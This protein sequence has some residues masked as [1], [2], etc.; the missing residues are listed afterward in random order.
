M[1]AARAHTPSRQLTDS[2]GLPSG[3]L[4]NIRLDVA[5]QLSAAYGKEAA[6]QQLGLNTNTTTKKYTEDDPIDHVPLRLGELQPK[7]GPSLE[8]YRTK[9][10]RGAAVE[11]RAI[12]QKLAEQGRPVVPL[13]GREAREQL[14]KNPA[15]FVDHAA[16]GVIT[17]T[18]HAR[19][20]G[21]DPDPCVAHR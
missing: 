6:A 12:E 1:P 15:L 5:A 21:E 18:D 8:A 3:G 13:R 2:V 16:V 17:I 7:P 10:E 11:L 14:S 9:V 19:A 4:H 20:L